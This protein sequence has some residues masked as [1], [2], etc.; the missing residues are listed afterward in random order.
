MDDPVR[1]LVLDDH[2]LS[3]RGLEI[4][5]G[6]EDG[7]EVVG[8][9]SADTPAGRVIDLR[10]DVVLID[11]RRFDP[12]RAACLTVREAAPS[13]RIRMME[14]P[15]GP[16]GD[17]AGDLFAEADGVMP[18]FLPADEVAEAI[19]EMMRDPR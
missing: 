14:S 3:R 11:G 16:G 5:L 1:V 19:R 13:A 9:T 17:T 15:C 8:A 10:P 6:A 18:K 4:V 7:I 12:A 2:R